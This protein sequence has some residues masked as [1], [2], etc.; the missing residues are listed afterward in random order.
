MIAAGIG[1][2]KGATG[3]AVAAAVDAALAAHRLS[4]GDLMILA[5]IEAKAAEPG[6]LEMAKLLG[7]P[8]GAYD[9]EALASFDS[10]TPTRSERSLDAAGV[11]CVCEASALAA[12]G[13]GARLLGP[14]L[15]L[16]PVTCALAASDALS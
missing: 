5:T 7:L 3:E 4:R 12:A 15:V 2:R 14:R 1:C 6:I 11:A 16:G 10:V 8:L 13:A 9:A